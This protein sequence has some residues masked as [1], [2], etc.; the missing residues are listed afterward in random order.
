M[1]TIENDIFPIMREFILQPHK[2]PAGAMDLCQKKLQDLLDKGTHAIQATFSHFRMYPWIQMRTN[3]SHF[4]A[5]KRV[6]FPYVQI[7]HVYIRTDMSRF[8]AYKRVTFPYVQMRHVSMRTNASRLCTY[9]YVTFTS[10]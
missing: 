7:C 4:H 10:V 6:T 8:H 9:K 1:N 2:S 3:M 5:Y